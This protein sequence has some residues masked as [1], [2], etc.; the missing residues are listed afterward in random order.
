MIMEQYLYEIM[1]D[2]KNAGS[3]TEKEEMET[4]KLDRF[5]THGPKSNIKAVGP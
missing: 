5:L 1:E 3:D 2:Y 4:P